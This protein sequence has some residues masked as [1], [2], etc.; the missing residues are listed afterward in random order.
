MGQTITI[1]TIIHEVPRQIPGLSA[2]MVIAAGAAKLGDL[3]ISTEALLCLRSIWNTA[4][5]RT[6]ILSVAL[7]AVSILFTLGMEWT[8]AKQVAEARRRLLD[9]QRET[10]DMSTS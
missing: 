4:V 9:T 10:F 8:N 5:S 2:D 6:M 1:N 3:G 7:V